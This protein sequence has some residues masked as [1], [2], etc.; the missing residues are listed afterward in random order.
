[1]RASIKK[2]L[3]DLAPSTLL[4][5][6]YIVFTIFLS[7]SIVILPAGLKANSGFSY[8]ASF[9]STIAPYLLGYFFSSLFFFETARSLKKSGVSHIIEIA[10][11][12]YAL[13]LIGLAATPHE[14]LSRSHVFFGSTLFASQ[15]LLVF[16]ILLVIKRQWF[17]F[18]I[19]VGQLLS[20]IVCAIY[21]PQETGHMIFGQT[22]FQLAFL[23]FMYDILKHNR[24]SK[25]LATKKQ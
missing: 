11:Y 24:L 12:L 15:L 14:T 18:F 8:Y 9:R 2:P 22:V 25:D 13:C 4:L 6:G 10:F 1:M 21:L 23:L 3:S 19:V 17:H 5:W 7:T 16:W 20:G